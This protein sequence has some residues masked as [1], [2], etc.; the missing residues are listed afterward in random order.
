MQEH[1]ANFAKIGR[2]A[3]IAC[4]Q[5]FPVMNL[6]GSR[7]REINL[8]R[9]VYLNQFLFINYFLNELLLIIEPPLGVIRE[10]GEWPLRPKGARS[11]A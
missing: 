11:M 5:N 2:F 6:P 9:A 4:T 3:K 8:S 1:L 7:F 10:Q